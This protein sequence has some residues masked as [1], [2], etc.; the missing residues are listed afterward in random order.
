MIAAPGRDARRNHPSHGRLGRAT[1]RGAGSLPSGVRPT[2]PSCRRFFPR[3]GARTIGANRPTRAGRPGYR[4][5]L[6]D[7][8]QRPNPGGTPGLPPAPA[9][10]PPPARTDGATTRST[11]VSAVQP[12]TGRD[13]PHPASGRR[14]RPAGGSF[15][16][17]GPGRS[18]PTVQPGRDARATT[19]PWTM[20]ANGPTRARRPRHRRAQNGCRPRQGRT[21]QPPVARPSRP[22]NRPRGGIAPIRRPAD[23]PALPAV[24]S[25]ER[26]PDDRR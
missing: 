21:A 17:E 14:S 25:Q 22:C 16:G 3:R 7:G 18:A 12:S 5:P 2:L 26:G 8:R 6:D 13:R 23:A 19:S 11:A 24:L 1:V 4:R 9:R 20:D 10:L 15:P